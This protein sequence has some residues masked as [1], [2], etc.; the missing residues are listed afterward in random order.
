MHAVH[1]KGLAGVRRRQALIALSVRS[2]RPRRTRHSDWRFATWIGVSPL[3]LAFRQLPSSVPPLAKLDRTDLVWNILIFF[4]L[5]REIG[6][7][8]FERFRVVS[9]SVVSPLSPTTHEHAL[10][11]PASISSWSPCSHVQSIAR[12]DLRLPPVWKDYDLLATHSTSP[13]WIIAF[14]IISN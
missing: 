8:P 14:L 4:Y 12:P 5:K 13:G 2:G 11:T 6:L 7:E 10:L 1:S 3:G 9:S